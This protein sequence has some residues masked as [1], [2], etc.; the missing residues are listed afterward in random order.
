[1]ETRLLTQN[2]HWGGGRHGSLFFPCL[3]RTA[4]QVLAVPAS[5]ASP[6]RVASKLGRLSLEGRVNLKAETAN[7]L[8]FLAQHK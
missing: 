2:F 4:R 5:S 7:V 8:T 3:A 1:M 6:E